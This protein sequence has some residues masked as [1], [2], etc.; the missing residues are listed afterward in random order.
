MSES[1][2]GAIEYPGNPYSP[3]G[4]VLG[5]GSTSLRMTPREEQVATL[6]ALGYSYKRI[7]AALSGSL[8]DT[9]VARHVS[10]VAARIPGAGSPR[11]KVSAWMWVY[12]GQ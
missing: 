7:S 12:G 8:S 10:A 11:Q 9:N 1:T 6:V 5:P 2:D 4:T 3:I